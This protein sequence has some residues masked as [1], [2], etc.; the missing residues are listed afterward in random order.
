MCQE[1]V[2]D[3]RNVAITAGI[4]GNPSEQREWGR[5]ISIKS[6]PAHNNGRKLIHYRFVVSLFEEA[7][8]IKC[9]HPH[10]S[11]IFF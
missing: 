11:R 10:Y 7:F 9:C 3:G 8:D 4:S 1:E 6:I 2:C 5:G